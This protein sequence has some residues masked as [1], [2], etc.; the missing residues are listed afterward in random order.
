M[1]NLIHK[2]VANYK[3]DKLI[4]SFQEFYNYNRTIVATYNGLGEYEV[5]HWTTLILRYDPKTS[6]I[7]F[8]D[9]RSISMTTSQLVGK[10]V[11]ALPTEAVISYLTNPDNQLS[12]YT[13]NRIAKMTWGSI[14][15]HLL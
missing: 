3:L 8:L 9:T 1:S 2:R 11:R 15:R 14:D 5:F 10:I 4:S 12:R 13:K 6:K 7:I